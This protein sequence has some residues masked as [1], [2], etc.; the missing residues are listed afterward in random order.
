MKELLY[1]RALKNLCPICNK[2]IDQD[3]ILVD[4]NDSKLKVCKTHI[5]Y[6]EKENEQK[7]G[8]IE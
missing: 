1:S 3:T 2:Q 6:G 8:S 5:K 4:Y 7:N